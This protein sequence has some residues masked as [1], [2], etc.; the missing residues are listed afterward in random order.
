MNFEYQQIFDH[1]LEK[2]KQNKN[3]ISQIFEN[4]KKSNFMSINEVL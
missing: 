3:I 1:T 2:K 4:E